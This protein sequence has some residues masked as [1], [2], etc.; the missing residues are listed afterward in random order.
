LKLIMRL[1]IIKGLN[2]KN[3]DLNQLEELQ[4]KLNNKKY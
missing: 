4:D 2:E 3:N 1:G